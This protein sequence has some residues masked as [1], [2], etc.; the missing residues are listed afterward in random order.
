VARGKK[1]RDYN[2]G[3]RALREFHAVRIVV[4]PVLIPSF[5]GCARR[6]IVEENYMQKNVAGVI[7]AVGV[8]ATALPCY[9]AISAAPIHEAMPLA[10]NAVA[11]MPETANA[12]DPNIQPVYW[13]YHYWHHWHHWHHHHS[14]LRII[15]R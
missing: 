15:I 9:A 10:T 4:L 1:R 3:R 2:E 13:H 8:M 12:A 7:V 14:G 6:A 5:A 11:A